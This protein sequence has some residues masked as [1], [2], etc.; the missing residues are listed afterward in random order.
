MRGNPPGRLRGNLRR[1]PGRMQEDFSVEP[2]HLHLEEAPL[3]L[4]E[5]SESFPEE[6]NEL[7][8]PDLEKL[9]KDPAAE[10]LTLDPY[11]EQIILAVLC[12]PQ[13]A[14]EALSYRGSLRS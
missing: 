9:E 5:Y 7:P 4:G 8:S 2:G 6:L 13:L 10:T 12:A 1:L 3:H 11:A 14:A